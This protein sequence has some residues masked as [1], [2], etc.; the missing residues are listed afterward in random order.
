MLNFRYLH[1]LAAICGGSVLLFAFQNFTPSNLNSRA[2]SEAKINEILAPATAESSAAVVD[3]S[4]QLPKGKSISKRLQFRGPQAS[5]VTFDCNGSILNE[6]GINAGKD[7]IQ[8]FSRKVQKNGETLWERPSDVTIKNCTVLGAVRIYGMNTNGEGA[9]L[10]AS[11]ISEGHTERAQA[12]APTRIVLDKMKIQASSRIPLYIS[13]GVTY[14]KLINSNISGSSTSVAVYLDAESGHNLIQNNSIHTD[15][16]KRELIAIDGSANN[17]IIGNRL[18][19]LDNG[20][21]YLYRN[22]GEGGTVRHQ[23]PS[24]NHI[25]NNI[26]YYNK[27]DGKN[28]AIWVASRNGN[29]NYCNADNGYAFGSSTNNNDLARNNVI[30]QNQF[31]KFQPEKIVRVSDSP[32]YLLGNETVSADK[33]RASGCYLKAA[34]PS[35]LLGHGQSTQQFLISGAVVCKETKYTCTDGVLS[36][37]K[38]TC[39]GVSVKTKP[40]DCQVSG[41]NSGCGGTVRCDSGQRIIGVRAAC[42]LENGR[43]PASYINSVGLNVASV[44]RASDNIKDG[45]CQIDNVSLSSGS[46]SL[47]TSVASTYLNYS[48][49]EYDKNGGDCHV[50]GQVLCQ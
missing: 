14:V 28:P 27:Y 7:M 41:N 11:S 6:A 17:R 18:S 8:V 22:C 32:N 25:I 42:N 46:V 24:G 31:Y 43:V 3:C 33:K 13:P 47:R 30:A 21:I 29:R 16:E 40:F 49:R 36:T 10:R 2:C 1:K 44:Q 20:G 4:A 50:I 35:E 37:A 15:T 48:C 5:G 45:R 12:A 19:A 39:Q 34:F 23:T 38:A 26:F 9:D